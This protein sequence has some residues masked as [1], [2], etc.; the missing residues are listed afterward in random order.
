VPDDRIFR[1][2]LY[3]AGDSLN[4]AQAHANLKALCREHLPDRH[5]I[6]IV[7][8]FKEP[9]R[10]LADGVLMTPTLQKLAPLPARTIVGTLSQPEPLLL[11]LGLVG[12]PA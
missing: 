2:R 10:A 12:D 4:S 3:V 8:V 5:A 7:D 11:A 1:F 6:E 9:R